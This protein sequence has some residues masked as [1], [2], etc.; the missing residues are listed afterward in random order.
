MKTTIHEVLQFTH[1]EIFERVHLV[2]LTIDADTRKARTGVLRL[3]PDLVTDALESFDGALKVALID[4]QKKRIKLLRADLNDLCLQFAM[5]DD[6]PLKGSLWGD[7]ILAELKPT[8][9]I[10]KREVLERLRVR[11]NLS[12]VKTYH[13]RTKFDH[14]VKFFGMRVPKPKKILMLQIRGAMRKMNVTDVV[15]GTLSGDLVLR[16][17]AHKYS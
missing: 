10:P 6:G 4:L 7:A 12:C 11:A 14:V 17:P 13:N 15:I 16:F 9:R 1:P 2:H 3:R 5:D 8:E